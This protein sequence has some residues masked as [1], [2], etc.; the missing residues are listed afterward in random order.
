MRCKSL[1]SLTGPLGD[2]QEHRRA[3]CWSTGFQDFLYAIVFSPQEDSS[4]LP[5]G[6]ACVFFV[7]VGFSLGFCGVGRYQSEYVAPLIALSTIILAVGISARARRAMVSVMVFLSAYSVHANRVMHQDVRYDMWPRKRITTESYFPYSRALRYLIQQE[8]G[9]NFVNVVPDERLR[10]IQIMATRLLSCVRAGPGKRTRRRF[11]PLPSIMQ[12]WELLDYY[13]SSGTTAYVIS[14]VQYGTKQ[15]F[16]HEWNRPG[17]HS[18]MAQLSQYRVI[19]SVRCKRL[20]LYA[21]HSRARM[22]V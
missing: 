19:P 22:R 1:L 4:V 12:T 7:F 2:T 16:Q 6:S 3:L 10:R 5:C 14:L 17:L 20:R 15:D 9:G 13:H 8:A 11:M 18:L 21:I